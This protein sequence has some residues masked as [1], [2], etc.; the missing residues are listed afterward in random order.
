MLE[1]AAQRPDDVEVGLPVRVGGAHG[2]VGRPQP[3]RPPGTARRGAGSVTPATATGSSTSV[4]P[5][6]SAATT[7][8]AASRAWAAVKAA[9]ANPHPQPL[10][11]RVVAV[12]MAPTL[13]PGAH[14]RRGDRR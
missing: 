9:S 11:S 13:V 1:G 12:A 14:A 8:G 3:G 2:V 10:R 4:V 6:P 7:P 5:K